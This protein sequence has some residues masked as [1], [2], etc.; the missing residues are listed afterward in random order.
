M[1]TETKIAVVI[2][3]YRAENIVDELCN[4]LITNLS[5]LTDAFEIL[6]IDDSSPDN[7]WEKIKENTLKDDRI[8]GYLLSRNFGQHHAI[9]AGLDQSNGKWIVVMDCD[10]QDRPEEIVRLHKKAQEGFDIVLAAR[11]RRKDGFFKRNYTYIDLP[12]ACTDFLFIDINSYNSSI[13]IKS[14]R[15]RMAYY[16][17]HS[18]S[19]D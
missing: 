6:L 19:D 5:K 14:R 1:N 18:S 17:I 12:W 10:L 3:V 4:R 13:F 9:T 2:P 8:K 11:K 7:S 15:S 16:I